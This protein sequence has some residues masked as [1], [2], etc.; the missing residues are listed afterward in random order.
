MHPEISNRTRLTALLL[1]LLVFGLFPAF[2]VGRAD[3]A[4]NAAAKALGTL[5]GAGEEDGGAQKIS[6]LRRIL[7]EIRESRRSL[8]DTRR[9]RRDELAEIEARRAELEL[10]RAAL[11]R[12]RQAVRKKAA[13]ASAT[14][15]E[16]K[17][18][19]QKKE[20]S[21]ANV[22]RVLRRNAQALFTFVRQGVPFD[23]EERSRSIA[24]FLDSSTPHN[25]VAT[26]R[27]LKGLYDYEISLGTTSSAFQGRI[28]LGD[29][30][31]RTRYMRAGLVYMLFVTED[32][33]EAGV[34]Q[35]RH[36]PLAGRSEFVWKTGLGYFARWR[37][38]HAVEI[39]EKKRPPVILELPVP[40]GQVKKP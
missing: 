39:A 21:L 31:P 26:A 36:D 16:L 1:L 28:E 7:Q 18:S 32:G 3:T 30:R 40:L 33:S 25:P 35:H 20:E 38:R 22:T 9:R 4:Q 19:V 23:L 5:L 15:S 17:T 34:L 27:T 24:T 12:E 2:K 8:L 37:V 14:R 10:A 11:V 29:E 6:E 13:A